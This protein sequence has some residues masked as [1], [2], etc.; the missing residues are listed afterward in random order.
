MIPDFKRLVGGAE[1]KLVLNTGRSIDQGKTRHDKFT[2]EY[3]KATAIALFN[4]RDMDQ[5]SL[6]EGDVVSLSTY[7]GS[8]RLVAKESKYVNEGIVFVPLGPYAN[9]LIPEETKDGSP[10]Y[11]SL[12]VSVSRSGEASTTWEELFK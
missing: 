6:I 7:G 2:D 8:V 11:K 5:A 9:A 12:H 1:L 4:K 10:F 3:R